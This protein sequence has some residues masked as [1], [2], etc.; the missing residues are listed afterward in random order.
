MKSETGGDRRSGKRGRGRS[1]P[2]AR[3]PRRT[4]FP[5]DGS[6]KPPDYVFSPSIFKV[7]PEAELAK[8]EEEITFAMPLPL[9]VIQ[10]QYLTLTKRLHENFINVFNIGSDTRAVSTIPFVEYGGQEVC[11]LHEWWSKLRG[12][13]TLDGWSRRALAAGLV[14]A[15]CPWRIGIA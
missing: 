15:C 1:P 11:R 3:T 9:T 6:P 13:K 5:G 2:P 4:L 12:A 10:T 14:T 8:N 7:P